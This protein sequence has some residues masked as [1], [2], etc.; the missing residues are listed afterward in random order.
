[1]NIFD[2]WDKNTDLDGLKKD[3][4]EAKKNGNSGTYKEVPEGT[5][6]VLIEKMELKES[7]KGDPMFSCWFKILTGDYKNSRIFMNQI[8]NQGFQIGIVNDFLRSLETDV[9]IEF[10]SYAK[11][12]DL[13]LDVMEEVDGSLEFLL[14]Y[15]KNSKG[16]N[17][18][19][20]K[21]VYE[22]E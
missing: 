18:Y 17:T 2:K 12:A 20:I 10:E 5:Y 22:V 15:G 14:D 6:E 4:E 13:I 16:F 7:S 1:M 9:D 21:E 8:V 19:R 11:Y 3:V